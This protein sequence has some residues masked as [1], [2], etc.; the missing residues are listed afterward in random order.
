MEGGKFRLPFRN[1]RTTFVPEEP[2][3]AWPPNH[4]TRAYRTSG[5]SHGQLGVASYHCHLIKACQ[6][7]PQSF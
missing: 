6:A 4:T 5:N 7:L 1:N 3:H 2:S